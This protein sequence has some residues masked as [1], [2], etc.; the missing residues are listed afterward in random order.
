MQWRTRDNF[1]VFLSAVNHKKTT[2]RASAGSCDLI[3]Y[4]KIKT[5]FK[6]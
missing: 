4:S 3:R 6:G 1:Y 5:E 2:A